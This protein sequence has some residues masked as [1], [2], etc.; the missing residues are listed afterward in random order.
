MKTKTIWH[1]WKTS[2]IK[3]KLITV[4]I[5]AL[6]SLGALGAMGEFSDDK[7]GGI[8]SGIAETIGLKEKS[9]NKGDSLSETL[10]PPNGTLQL[11]KEYVYAGSR[12]VATEDY[13]NSNFPSRINMALTSNGGTAFA[14][15]EANSGH[16]VAGILNG[17]RKGL[18]WGNG[19]GWSE[20]APW[21]FP[22]WVQ[23]NFNGTK[24]IDEVNVF[25][26][27]DNYTNPTEPT[28]AMTF[29][30]YGITALEIQYRNG[31]A[32]VT[33]P[34]GIQT[35]NNKIWS[36]FVFSAVT[37]NSIR[38]LI[39]GNI[40]NDSHTRL[41]EVEAFGVPSAIPIRTN[42]ALASNG[43]VVS[44]SSQHPSLPPAAA[45]NGD[46]RGINW[47]NGGG[48]GDG[49][50]GSFPDWLQINFSSA[51]TIDEIDV[52]GVQD[53]YTNPTEPTET[54]TFT[55]YGLTAL[56][57]QYWN[58]SGWVTV[59]NGVITNNNK[60]WSKFTFSPITTGSI[61]IL[62]HGAGDSWS[63]ITEVEAYGMP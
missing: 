38:V 49:T 1:F 20:A 13:G 22:D 9:S 54:M 21:A 29:T 14:S 34:N 30:Q 4:G 56:E 41:T 62:T 46:R 53:A 57:A 33:V 39:H 27:Q 42:F 23:I 36:K 55:Q 31:S 32:W 3:Q 60:I 7:K 40:A 50:P 58:G 35:N 6:L 24:Q 10:T 15:S 51:K 18:N 45:I 28:E 2:S 16:S 37:T 8:L 47:V 59:P 61:R 5:L 48:W 43:A 17:D 19:G 11:S 52:F 44:S 26:V 12:M 25:G 63:R